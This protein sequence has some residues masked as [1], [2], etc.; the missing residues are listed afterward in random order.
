LE[1]NK[2]GPGDT[3]GQISLLTGMPST[4]TFN[5]MTSGLLLQ[6][7]SED[8]KPIIDAR[9]ELAEELCHYVSQMQEFLASFERTALRPVAAQQ[10]DLIWRVKSFFRLGDHTF[11]P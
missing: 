8:L 1:V 4:V 2:L 9:P 7:K 6:L 10:H 3:F 5:A 11:S